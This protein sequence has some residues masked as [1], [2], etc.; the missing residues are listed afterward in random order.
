MIEECCSC[1]WYEEAPF[2]YA[3]GCG[4]CWKHTSGDF[5]KPTCWVQGVDLSCPDFKRKGEE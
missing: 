4:V 1:K 3:Q 5:D 2:T